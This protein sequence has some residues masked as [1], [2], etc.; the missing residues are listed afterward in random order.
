[1]W[2]QIKLV[3]SLTL[4]YYHPSLI[5]AVSLKNGPNVSIKKDSQLQQ[6]QNDYILVNVWLDY[7]VS[8]P[9]W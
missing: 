8:H 1:M 2:S 7:A 4:T 3:Q 6:I 9:V 5:T